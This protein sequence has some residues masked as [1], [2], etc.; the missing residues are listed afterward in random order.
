M[1]GDSSSTTVHDNS[2]LRCVIEESQTESTTST[3]E[4]T[5]TESVTITTNQGTT[6]KPVTTTT[7][8]AT[9]TEPVGNTTKGDT[10]A[11]AVTITTNATSVT[12]TN[13]ETDK[14]TKESSTKP[15]KVT[16]RMEPMT[17][18]T[19]IFCKFPFQVRNI[20]FWDCVSDDEERGPVC[21]VEQE[22]SEI[23]NFKDTS[24]F[25]LCGKCKDPCGSKSNYSYTG[26]PVNNQAGSKKYAKVT[27]LEDC[28]K[29]C[30]QVEEC[31][32]FNY[33]TTEQ[34]CELM[35]GVGGKEKETD[36]EV[37]FGQQNCPGKTLKFNSYLYYF[38]PQLIVRLR[39][40]LSTIPADASVTAS[41]GKKRKSPSSSREH[42]GVEMTVVLS[43]QRFC[44]RANVTC[45]LV[46]HLQL[47]QQL[48]QVKILVKLIT[49]I[50]KDILLGRNII[51]P[52][53]IHRSYRSYRSNR[54]PN[55]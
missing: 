17:V 47:L 5:T 26:F 24:T 27:S 20:S 9:V 12:D 4:D 2:Y 34:E 21:N 44:R 8:E 32:F 50:D 18:S 38:H 14:K 42:M 41:R 22:G 25:Q 13:A 46:L 33:H 55:R 28:Q 49:I 48:H 37:Y 51:S 1:T 31:N 40:R 11:E 29:L 7:N 45:R 53:E 19:N 3:K 30:Q 10:T 6:T 35:Y 15:D 36:D 52:R 16:Q 43:R 23:P 39:K 54:S